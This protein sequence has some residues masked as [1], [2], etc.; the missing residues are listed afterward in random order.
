MVDT[1]PSR[2]MVSAI[3]GPHWIWNGVIVGI[4]NQRPV[5]AVAGQ[6]NLVDPV[7]WDSIDIVHRLE[8]VVVGTDMDIV[9]I[10]QN[11]TVGAL[12]NGGKKFPL[13]HCRFFITQI[14]RHIF[15][16]DLAS[17]S[18]LYPLNAFCNMCDRFISV[19]HR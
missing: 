9:D 14:A 16:K 5:I 17:E 2:F 1:R 19:R 3:Q 15:Q 10:Q 8:A 7:C 18:V 12:G 13:A 11:E 4:H 6:M